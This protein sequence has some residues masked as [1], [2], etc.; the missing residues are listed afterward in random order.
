MSDPADLISAFEESYGR[1][2]VLRCRQKELETVK[3]LT[4]QLSRELGIGGEFKA[5]LCAG[6]GVE[7]VAMD[8]NAK[9]IL[10]RVAMRLEP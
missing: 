3:E 6:F 10:A 5:T 4:S 8:D 2:N 9:K 1:L 7:V